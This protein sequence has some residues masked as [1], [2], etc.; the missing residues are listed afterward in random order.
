MNNLLKA[1]ARKHALA[2]GIVTAQWADIDFDNYI[3]KHNITERDNLKTVAELISDA[4]NDVGTVVMDELENQVVVAGISEERVVELIAENTAPRVNV[5][6]VRKG[7]KVLGKV[8]GA[9]KDYPV[10]LAHIAAG[11]NTAIVGPAGSGKSHMFKDIAKQLGLDYYITGAVQQES[12][13]MGYMTAD[14]KYV[15]TPFRDAYEHGGL[16][17]MEEFDGSG[18]KA[19]LAINNHAANDTADFPDGMVKRHEDFVLVM[20]GNTFGT[21]ASR[22][23]VGRSQLD[24]ATLNRFCFLE[25]GYDEDLEMAIVTKDYPA[26]ESWVREVQ[27]FRAKVERAGIRHVVSPRNSIMGAKLLAQG[28]PLDVVRKSALTQNLTADQVKQLSKV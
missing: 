26:A 15:R 27:A 5:V 2:R 13:V 25:V 7:D 11:V 9:H 20:A 28:L 16:F 23:Y 4:E 1:A 10:V 14:G 17:V 8:E 3:A 18:A 19:L 12:K 6:E 21:G 24:A 22:Q